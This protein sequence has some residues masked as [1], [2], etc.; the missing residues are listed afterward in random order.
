M[1]R[2][3]LLESTLYLLAAALFIFGFGARATDASAFVL[4]KKAD[5]VL[6]VMT[7][8]VG[9]I[10]ESG[11]WG[12]PLLD[13][14]VEHA[15]SVVREVD[16]DLC[17]LQEVRSRR[18]AR[19]IQDELGE[20]WSLELAKSEYGRMVIVLVQRGTIEDKSFEG[21]TREAL[22]LT[23]VPLNGTPLIA[24]GLHA[25]VSSADNRNN[26]IGMVVDF[27]MKQ[28]LPSILMGDLNID[29]DI[30]KRRDLFTDNEYLDVETYNF[31]ATRLRDVG[32]GTGS[33]AEPDRRL[34]YIFVDE[35]AFDS[36]AAGP[37]KN[38]RINNMD[39]DPVIADLIQK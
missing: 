10:S 16:P 8:N 13:A 6:R 1:S 22:G 39:H 12:S 5:E 33:T 37:L 28:E 35:A 27:L 34:D 38:R 20:A 7:W 24:V 17:F 23:Y 31:I 18:Q 29:L 25:D 26:E 11:E 2:E 14:N 30:D 36:R 15:A 32:R 19:Q 3:A 21:T 4:T 9:S